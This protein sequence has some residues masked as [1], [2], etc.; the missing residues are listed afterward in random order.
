MINAYGYTILSKKDKKRETPSYS[1]RRD[2]SKHI[3]REHEGS[4]RKTGLISG[5]ITRH[6][7]RPIWSYYKSGD[8]SWQDEN[9]ATSPTASPPF[10]EELFTQTF[11]WPVMTSYDVYGRGGGSPFRQ[12]HV[13]H[14]RIAF[15]SSRV[16]RF[17]FNVANQV[18][19]FATGNT[20][21]N[22]LTTWSWQQGH[23]LATKGHRN[24]PLADLV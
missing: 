12:F 21:L 4:I 17:I 6:Y 24:L 10:C 23:S 15:E 22:L 1:S 7:E 13:I 14:C 5:E 16:A 18:R 3:H 19:I 11:L 20:C 2:V 8:A 9:N